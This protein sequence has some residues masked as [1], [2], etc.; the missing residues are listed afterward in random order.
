MPA[1]ATSSS[2]SFHYLQ[3]PVSRYSSHRIPTMPF[4]GNKWK[5]ELAAVTSDSPNVA[6]IIDELSISQFSKTA[7]HFSLS[8]AHPFRGSSRSQKYR[9]EEMVGD[10]P[11]GQNY[12]AC[13]STG[14][15][16][17]CSKN[18][19]DPNV[20]CPENKESEIA[21][22]KDTSSNSVANLIANTATIA[23]TE[24]STALDTTAGSK[25][26]RRET[27]TVNPAITSD[28]SKPSQA[29]MNTAFI[30]A[31]EDLVLAPTCPG[32]NG[33]R[34]S[35]ITNIAYTVRCNYDSTATSYNT[36]QIS[37][38]GYAQCFS[39]CSESGDCGGFTYVGLNDGIC[40]LKSRMLRRQYVAKEGNNYI[41][42]NKIDHQASATNSSTS[43][44]TES[45]TPTSTPTTTPT[46]AASGKKPNV[47]P[48]AGGAIGGVAILALMLFL[49]AYLARRH[50][51]QVEHKRA[52]ITHIFGGAMEPPRRREEDNS[53]NAIP[54]HTRNGSTSH[55]Y[56]PF[57]AFGGMS[58][59]QPP[60]SNVPAAPEY[61]PQHARQRSTYR[62][63]MPPVELNSL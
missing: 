48:I 5:S 43:S 28:T 20:V 33:T 31:T 38:G 22:S 24:G 56:S 34:Y 26:G 42:C 23:S 40:Y 60:Y 45:E 1:K 13:Q 44:A 50:R 58:S 37:T 55:D 11:K 21:S 2:Q 12:Y 59:T 35:D 41:S 18:A 53:T 30:R 15:K 7:K 49:I 62:T 4:I 10:C 16:G 61:Q 29:T 8:T 63:Y 54:L 19:C 51:K 27:L 25:V 14:F 9:K 3:S 32:G 47:G 17:C 52:T 6:S 46:P 36:V 57:A 39:S